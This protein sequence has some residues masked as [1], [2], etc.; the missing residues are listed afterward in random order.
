MKNDYHKNYFWVC[1]DELGRKKYYFNIK[2]SLIEVDKD[3]F[4]VC[5]SSYKKQLRQQVKD[6]DADLVS[7]QDVNK[8]GSELSN[9]VGVDNDYINKLYNQEKIAEI[10]NS[11]NELDDN[12]REL[13]TNLLIK[14]KTEKEMA[15][16]FN[17][18]QQYTNKRK[19]L[20]IE[21]IKKKT[22]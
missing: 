6:I 21:K 16:Q 13:I 17:V 11:I 14:E 7:F 12:D 8:D 10:M 9:F 4:N 2:G 22:L 15:I 5:Y 20:I 19:H 18:S 3:V 1:P